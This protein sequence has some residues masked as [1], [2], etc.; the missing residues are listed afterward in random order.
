MMNTQMFD[1]SGSIVITDNLV[2]VLYTL[3]RDEIPPGKLE[4]IVRDIESHDKTIQYTN[5]WLAL[6]AK[7][8]AD[9]LR[10]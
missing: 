6:Y 10:S 8:L 3:M 1:R 2:S 5:G 7:D 4:A 9:R